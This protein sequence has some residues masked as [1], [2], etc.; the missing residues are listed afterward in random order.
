M[1]EDLNALTDKYFHKSMPLADMRKIEKEYRIKVGVPFD[2]EEEAMQQRRGKTHFL[3]DFWEVYNGNRDQSGLLNGFEPKTWHR[4][5]GQQ[6]REKREALNLEKDSSHHSSSKDDTKSKNKLPVGDKMQTEK[7]RSASNS[8]PK[9]GRQ[10]SLHSMRDP[11]Y[12]P[13]NAHRQ[14]LQQNATNKSVKSSTTTT[15]KT[16]A[17]YVDPLN[18]NTDEV[19]ARILLTMKYDHPSDAHEFIRNFDAKNF[20]SA[21]EKGRSLFDQ[22]VEIL[23]RNPATSPARQP[24]EL[25]I[26]GEF[27]RPLKSFKRIADFIFAYMCRLLVA[28]SFEDKEVIFRQGDIGM[29]WYVILSGHVNIMINKPGFTSADEAPERSL[30]ATLG[31]GEGFGDHALVND[32]P[33]VASAIA[34]GA[35]TVVRLEKSDFR[36]LMSLARI[37]R[38]ADCNAMSKVH[39]LD[40]KEIVYFLERVSLLKKLD[41]RALRNIADRMIMRTIPPGTILIREGEAKE[42]V[43][44]IRSGLCAVF[45][46]V[47]LTGK[48]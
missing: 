7:E 45:R 35:T 28:E 3:G 19:I 4:L 46:T 21:A 23:R 36:R 12:Q 13:S 29:R 31:V 41:L 11:G 18:L 22:A 15:N 2:P 25:Q 20:S 30:A 33:R 37:D 27:L 5:S 8:H 32:V 9:A 47:R 40:Q 16:R 1:F 26:I 14:A 48:E 44:F 6:Y 17:H 10:T 24:N 43:F 34:E 42:S 39:I 38:V